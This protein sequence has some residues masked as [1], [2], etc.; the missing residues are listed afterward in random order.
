[1]VQTSSHVKGQF[2]GVNKRGVHE[3]DNKA[4]ISSTGRRQAVC[5]AWMFISLYKTVYFGG[6]C[7]AGKVHGK[8]RIYY[9][10]RIRRLCQDFAQ[11]MPSCIFLCRTRYQPVRQENIK[12]IRHQI[13]FRFQ[14]AWH[15]RT[16]F[17]FMETPGICWQRGGSLKNV[18]EK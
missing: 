14:Y 15:Q 7:Q 11:M 3:V 17:F 16:R 2:E 10:G 9:N 8:H 4:G 6:I 13:S 5:P 18:G 12:E 1:M